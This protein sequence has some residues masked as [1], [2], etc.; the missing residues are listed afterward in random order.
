VVFKPIDPEIIQLLA[1]ARSSGPCFCARK[2]PAFESF[3]EDEL[4]Y[5][6]MSQDF[7]G[8]VG[9]LELHR[10]HLAAGAQESVHAQ[11]ASPRPLVELSNLEPESQGAKL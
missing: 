1:A 4:A 2:F 9:K 11:V 7:W 10:R 5:M 6:K 8:W 3:A